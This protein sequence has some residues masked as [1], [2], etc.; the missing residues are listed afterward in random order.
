MALHAQTINGLQSQADNIK[1]KSTPNVIQQASKTLL[2]TLSGTDNYVAHNIG[3]DMTLLY[4]K[5]KDTRDT[6][7]NTQ[8]LKD[9]DTLDING[10]IKTFDNIIKSTNNRGP[11][12]ALDANNLA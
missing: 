7:K 4:D 6:I 9:A 1:K 8:T 2:A 5:I 3:E 10:D 12:T 11:V